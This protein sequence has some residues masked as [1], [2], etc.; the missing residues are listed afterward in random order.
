MQEYTST[1]QVRKCE[2]SSNSNIKFKTVRVVQNKLT[3]Y[4]EVVVGYVQ[5]PSK[6]W[7]EHTI[8]KKDDELW[9]ATAKISDNESLLTIASAINSVDYQIIL[10]DFNDYIRYK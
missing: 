4:N 5:Y 3:G 6:M 7:Y 1:F 8:C 9:I 10:C 2:I